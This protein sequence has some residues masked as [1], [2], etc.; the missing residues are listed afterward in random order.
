MP[1]F[2]EHLTKMNHCLACGKD[3]DG[4]MNVDDTRGP[5]E[6]DVSICIYC[7]T[8]S[9]FT[10]DIDLRPMTFEEEYEVMSGPSGK[11]MRFLQDR[12]QAMRHARG[13]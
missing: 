9:V 11:R 3:L 13:S 10:K 8:L 7:G 1:E 12:I 5:Q 4:A 6:G 2:N